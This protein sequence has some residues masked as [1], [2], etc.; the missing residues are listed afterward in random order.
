MKRLTKKSKKILVI[1]KN[2]KKKRAQQVTLD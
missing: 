2:Y 1:Q